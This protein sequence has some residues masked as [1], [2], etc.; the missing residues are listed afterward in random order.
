MKI[1]KDEKGIHLSTSLSFL[2]ARLIELTFQLGTT[3]TAPE[4]PAT[5][6]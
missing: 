6:G 1:L 3:G 4:P 2:G 5:Q